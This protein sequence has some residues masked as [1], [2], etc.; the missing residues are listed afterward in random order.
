MSS[1]VAPAPVKTRIVIPGAEAKSERE[2]LHPWQDCGPI[3]ELDA[4]HI[5]P[6][7]A[8]RY[9]LTLAIVQELHREYVA[10][11]HWRGGGCYLSDIYWHLTEYV[12]APIAG[13]IPYAEPANLDALHTFIKRHM[14]L[15]N[16]VIVEVGRAYNLPQN[17]AGVN[18]HFVT[19]A[20]IDSDAGYLVLN[21]DTREAL[22]TAHNIVQAYWASW[23]TLQAAHLCGAIAVKRIVPTPPPVTPTPPPTPPVGDSSSENLTLAQQ[24]LSA[25]QTLVAKLGG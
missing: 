10:Y 24:A 15:Q 1:A 21:G 18:Y 13:Y 22:T 2:G 9:P 16:P 8:A 23:A 25:L 4:L 14:L 19:L 12:K 3:A 20:G 5:C 7:F 17:E 6:Q 11:G